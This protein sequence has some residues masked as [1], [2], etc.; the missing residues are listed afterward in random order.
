MAETKTET[1]PCHHLVACAVT[2]EAR[3]RAHEAIAAWRDDSFYTSVRH[4]AVLGLLAL[5]GPC[6]SREQREE[7]CSAHA[8][9]VDD[10][11]GE[12]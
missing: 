10:L 8:D 11:R 9:L 7:A 6:C 5:T 1:Q 3:L 12:Q 2:H 4:A